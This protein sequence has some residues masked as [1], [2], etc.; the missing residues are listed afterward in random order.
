MTL[1]GSW[2]SCERCEGES[3][4]GM[5]RA[6]KTV[7]RSDEC[8]LFMWS[9]GRPGREPVCNSARRLFGRAG[10]RLSGRTELEDLGSGHGQRQRMVQTSSAATCSHNPGSN[11]ARPDA[12]ARKPASLP[13]AVWHRQAKSA[14]ARKLSLEVH[15]AFDTILQTCICA[16][17]SGFVFRHWGVP[18]GSVQGGHSASPPDAQVVRPERACSRPAHPRKPY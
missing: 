7:G 14:S 17:P 18:L 1:P 16:G 2:P 12:P 5:R 11:P 13:A 3:R 9:T 10:G 6:V 8:V 4:R 15:S